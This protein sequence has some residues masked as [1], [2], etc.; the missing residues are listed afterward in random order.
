VSLIGAPGKEGVDGAAVSLAG[1]A[2]ADIGGEELEKA[3]GGA[4][5]GGGDERRHR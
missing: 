2:V 3:A 5:A 4:R 1:V